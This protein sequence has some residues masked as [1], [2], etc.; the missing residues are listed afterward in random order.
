MVTPMFLQHP[1]NQNSGLIPPGRYESQVTRKRPMP[2][3]LCRPTSREIRRYYILRFNRKFP[4]TIFLG[5][6]YIFDTYM[7]DANVILVRPMKSLTKEEYIEK[8]KEIYKYLKSRNYA[9]KLHVMDN[10]CSKFLKDYLNE[11][12]KVRTQL[13]ESDIH[14]INAAK[15]AIQTYKNHLILGLCTV[16]KMF[17]LQLWDK[18]LEQ[19]EITLNLLQTSRKNP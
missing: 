15:Q 1:N 5:N 8:F 2:D 9:P 19:L 11:D 17:P 14:R 18:T 7:Y 12:K 4:S 16:D 3:V 6:Q 13:V 10:E